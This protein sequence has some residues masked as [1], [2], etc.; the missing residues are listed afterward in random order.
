MCVCV[1]VTTVRFHHLWSMKGHV[2]LQVVEILMECYV[3][4][5][6]MYAL[7]VILKLLL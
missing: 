6:Y 7:C 3:Y 2:F 5:R 4:F 1:C